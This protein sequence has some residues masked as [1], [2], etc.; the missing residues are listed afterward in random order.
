VKRFERPASLSQRLL[1]HLV[2]LLWALAL[3]VADV[4][5]FW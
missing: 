5:I 4:D 2:A 1:D 3:V